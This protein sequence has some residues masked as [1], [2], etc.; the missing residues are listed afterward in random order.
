MGWPGPADYN[1]AIQNPQ[2]AFRDHRLKEC[3]VELK[4]GKPWPWPRAGANAIVYRLQNGSWSTAVRV[5]MNAPRPERQARYQLVHAYLQQTKP[6]C[7]VDFGYEADG[8]Q[9]NGQWLPILT[10]EWVAG[11][12]LGVWFREA[13]ERKDSPAIKQMAHEWVKLICELRSHKIAHCDLQHGNVMVKDDKLLLVDYDG[14]FVPAMDTGDHKDRVAW[15]N[16]LPAYQHPARTGQLLSPAIDDFSAWLILISL[17]AVADDLSLWHRMIGASEEESL[18]FT[19]K[20]IKYPGRSLLWPELIHNAKDRMVREW[21]AAL[22]KSLDGPFDEIPPFNIDIFGPL[23][24]VIKAGDWRQILELA[25]SRRYASETFPPDLAPK[26]NEAN[27][28]VDCAQRFEKKIAGGKLREIAKEYRPEL[29]DDWLDPA[30]V[31]K[32]RQARTAVVLLDEFARSEQSDPTGR[33][34]LAL[35][36]GHGRELQGIA[37]GDAV[38]NRVDTWR[39]R[40]AA[41]E[42]LDQTVGKGG[43]EKAI[44][45]AWQAVDALG[46]HP[47]AEPHRGR[48]ETAGKR[49]KALSVLA[50]VPVGEDEPADRALLKAWNASSTAVDGCTEAD[51]FRARVQA[52]R[53]RAQK[54][55]ELKNR[56]A[57]ADQGRGSEQA[58]IDAAGA[59]PSGYG[60]GFAD[61][62][63]QARERLASSAA[64]DQAL[65]ASPPSDVSIAAAAE[66]ARADGTWPVR[67]DVAARCELAI[68]RRDL[69]RVLDAIPTGLPLDEQDAQWTAAWDHGL[70]A[71]CHDAREHRNRQAAAVARMGAFAALEQALNRGDAVAVKRLARDSKLA[72]HP[73]L[74]RR[75]AEVNGLIAKSEQVERLVAAARAG[76]AEAFLAEADTGLLAAHAAEFAPFRDRIA[77][78]VDRRLKQGDILRPAD[79]VFIPDAGGTAVTARWAWAQSRLVRT[80]LVATDTTRFLEHPDEARHGTFNVDPDTHR[81]TKGGMIFSLPPGCRKLFISVWPVADLGWDRRIGPPLRIGPYVSAMAGQPRVADRSHKTGPRPW[82]ARFRTWFEHLLNW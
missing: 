23:R 58:V 80:C 73:G 60:A 48:A 24:E 50:G 53:G 59:L 82:P 6:K 63:R 79:P 62:L 9:V 18:L 71:D 77:G 28:R 51:A 54:Y 15:E 56:I 65:L 76:Q 12:T 42:R 25:T 39:K 26:V 69:L 41:A 72:D 67:A 30:L 61:R 5:F 8:I 35:W 32:G 47:D 20:D 36:D 66:R 64:L 10:M 16:G 13:V 34:L 1:G 81:R 31:A 3:A 46:G 21:S 27:K 45:E 78:W 55:N 2:A 38:R 33:Q 43:S 68:R 29:L 4:P 70:L 49:L 7:A 11:K 17:R 44:F 57:A 37:E 74:I 14:M 40:I 75:R 52:A 22:R 19:E